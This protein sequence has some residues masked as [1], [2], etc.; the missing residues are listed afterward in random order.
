MKLKITAFLMAALLI[1]SMTS[2]VALAADTNSIGVIGKIEVTSPTTENTNIPN[3]PTSPETGDFIAI[4]GIV[5]LAVSCGAV[6][7]VSAKKSRKI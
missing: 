6:A 7:V 1:I 2:I 5:F 4:G 3:K